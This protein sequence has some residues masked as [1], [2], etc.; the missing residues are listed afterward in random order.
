MA[1]G[2]IVDQKYFERGGIQMLKLR[3]RI[4]RNRIQN[5][6]SYLISIGLN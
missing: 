1:D 4:R 5:Y 6:N 3:S 2:E